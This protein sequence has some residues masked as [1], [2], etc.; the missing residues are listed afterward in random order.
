[1]GDIILTPQLEHDFLV[2]FIKRMSALTKKYL[3][4]TNRYCIIFLVLILII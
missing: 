4:L 3:L 2:V 1:L